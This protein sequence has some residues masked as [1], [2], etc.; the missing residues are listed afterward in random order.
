MNGEPLARRLGRLDAVQPAL[1]CGGPLD[2]QLVPWFPGAEVAGGD[3]SIEELLKAC[4]DG[5]WVSGLGGTIAEGPVG[6][7]GRLRAWTR[8]GTFVV[9]RGQLGARC[10]EAWLRLPAQALRSVVAVS[11]ERRCVPWPGRR[12]TLV[13]PAA[14]LDGAQLVP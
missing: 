9:R 3:Q 8:D 13:V 4:D 1:C 7:G 6:A 10:A 14:V 5:V 11:R 12:G 2:G